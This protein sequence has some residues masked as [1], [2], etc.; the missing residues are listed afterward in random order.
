MSISHNSDEG[1][2]P[3]QP[4]L[5]FKLTGSQAKTQYALELNAADMIREAGVDSCVFVTITCGQKVDGLFVCEPSHDVASKR[6]NN[7]S[8][9]LFPDLFER[10]IVV[11]E[12]HKNGGVH[13]HLLAVVKGRPDV[14]TGFIFRGVK[15]R[16]WTNASEPLRAV[17][18]VLNARLP[19][20][21]FGRPQTTPIEKTGEAVA[22]YVSKY[23]LKNLFARG[24][25][26][27]GK[28]LVRYG[29]FDRHVRPND[30]SWQT[31]RATAWRKKAE[32]L[33]GLAGVDQ[34]ES[35][36]GE[37]AEAFGPRW[38]F[39]LTRI[40]HA[41]DDRPLPAFEWASTHERECAR[42]F[43]LRV[44]SS[45]WVLRRKVRNSESPVEWCP[46]WEAVNEARYQ[47]VAPCLNI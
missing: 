13:F 21:G 17:W 7:A 2:T 23:V 4:E 46:D 37:V 33:A 25:E 14:R 9:R 41:V 26:D 10:W 35:G 39:K 29:G 34:G 42:Q 12:R 8:R 24:E 36:R 30:F 5:P 32:E 1:G 38:A 18:R 20:L 28:K 11:T 45:R 43:V 19:E 31:P 15:E 6:I 47:R 44:A 22:C 16:T 3:S 27:K 40:M